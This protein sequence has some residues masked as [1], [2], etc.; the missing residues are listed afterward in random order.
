MSTAFLIASSRPQ[1][2]TVQLANLVAEKLS[3][4]SVFN[5]DD[6]DISVYDYEHRNRHDDFLPLIEKLVSFDHVVFVTPV[7]WYAM[8][9][10]LKIFFDR[11]SDLLTIEKNL[12]RKLKGLN[13]SVI[14][15]GSWDYPPPCF[16]DVFKLTFSYLGMPYQGMLY[17]PV[18]EDI[19]PNH[20]IPGISEFVARLQG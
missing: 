6:Y 13:C 17:C 11:F 15:T 5:L 19:D 18:D 10:Q 20:S 16:E 2:N 8:S 12:G 1:G 7:Y 4:V 14:A 3:R 9:A